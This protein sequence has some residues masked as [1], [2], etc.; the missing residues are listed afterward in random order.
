MAGWC[1]CPPLF[2]PFWANGNLTGLSGRCGH[3][4]YPVD[5]RESGGEISEARR[6]IVEDRKGERSEGGCAPDAAGHDGNRQKG[7]PSKRVK[8]ATLW[9]CS[10]S[11]LSGGRR[12]RSAGTKSATLSASL[13]VLHSNSSR[14]RQGLRP[15]PPC[16]WWLVVGGCAGQGPPG[17][18]LR[19]FGAA[20]PPTERVGPL[21]PTL[22]WSLLGAGDLLFHVAEGVSPSGHGGEDPH[23]PFAGVA[24]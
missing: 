12:P 24:P 16:G 18:R 2:L 8:S 21:G 1:R 11:P 3:P 17:I 7:K 14:P 10:V 15:D 9:G 22:A 19:M 6:Q 20:F 23:G 5:R 4:R 13:L